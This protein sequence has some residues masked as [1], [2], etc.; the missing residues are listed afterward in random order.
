LKI[1]KDRVKKSANNRLLDHIDFK[2]VKVKING[3]EVKTPQRLITQ[4]EVFVDF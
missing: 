1:L 2:K 3:I 4:Q